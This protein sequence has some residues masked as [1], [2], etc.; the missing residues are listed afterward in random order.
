MAR[1]IQ[2][3]YLNKPDNFVFYTMNDFFLKTGFVLTD[4]RGEQIYFAGNPNQEG[5][6]CLKWSY[7][8]GMFHLEAWIKGRIEGDE[9]DLNG[10]E[11]GPQ[12]AIFRQNLEQLF[13]V[14]QGSVSQ[15]PASNTPISPINSSIPSQDKDYSNFA[16][17]SFV[18][19]ILSIVMIFAPLFSIVMGI[20]GIVLSKDGCKSS[21]ATL[22]KAGRIC[23][24][25]G[26]I[27]SS[28]YI[29]FIILYFFFFIFITFISLLSA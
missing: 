22:A 28:L 29:L 14:L 25:I 16:V 15:L 4:W 3:I 11:Y 6:K 10:S 7:T 26:I 12:K 13:R 9:W 2:D 8:N 21:Q 20:A 1:Y 18:F 27:G 24:I 23:S 5:C 19:G 17:I